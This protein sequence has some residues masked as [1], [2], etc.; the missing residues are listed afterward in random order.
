MRKRDLELG[1]EA[2][3]QPVA[4]R[5]D[6]ED[7]GLLDDLYA[8]V[9]S[10][11]R[12]LA[13]EADNLRALARGA[14][15]VH[16]RV[17]CESLQAAVDAL[18]A[19]VAD[20]RRS[21]LCSARVWYQLHDGVELRLLVA[22]RQLE[23]FLR[24]RA[25]LLLRELPRD[26]C[27][28][29]RLVLVAQPRGQPV[30]R[31]MSSKASKKKPAAAETK[32]KKRT[33]ASSCCELLLLGGAV[34]A[35]EPDEQS[36]SACLVLVDGSRKGKRVVEVAVECR[37]DGWSDDRRRVR[38]TVAFPEGT[39]AVPA[40]LTFQLAGRIRLWDGSVLGATAVRTSNGLPLVVC[41]N[42]NQWVQAEGRILHHQLFGSDDN[43]DARVPYALAAN[44]LAEVFL[45]ASRQDVVDAALLPRAELDALPA[46]HR[47][48]SERELA[49][50]RQRLGDEAASARD[51]DAFWTWLGPF[52]HQ[53]RHA[54]T[55]RAL[56]LHGVVFGLVSPSQVEELLT[57]R[58]GYFLFFFH[59]ASRNAEYGL[60][61]SDAESGTVMQRKL[62]VK[63]VKP[64]HGSLADYVRDKRELTMLV[65]PFR[66]RDNGVIEAQCVAVD[67][68]VAL[69]PY[70]S[71]TA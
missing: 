1:Q 45:R 15:A 27:E 5:L 47:P 50:I 43:P 8:C 28:L 40:V 34:S 31:A 10:L 46:P 41:T 69:A 7:A 58:P 30:K 71:P 18:A 22:Q 66:E 26:G 20:V 11:E 57:G 64:P 67:K 59:E 37:T 4:K 14:P 17:S 39:Q 54:P 56:L 32:A 51:V 2:A 60:A 21:R 9:E 23:V 35:F 44:C 33:A 38:C 13:D 52:W 61:F 19:R 42:E 63:L 48:L 49:C 62:D 25:A 68:D 70:Y 3:V 36:L 12:D 16:P 55:V 6:G 29:F 53:I 65:V 24:E